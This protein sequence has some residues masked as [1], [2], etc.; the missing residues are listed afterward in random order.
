M[1]ASTTAAPERRPPRGGARILRF[2]G[3]ERLFHWSFALP[4][5]LL[6]VSGVILA[7]PDTQT[8]LARR[9]LIRAIHLYA[10]V[11]LVLLPAAALLTD[12]RGI[13]RDLHEIDYWDR[14]DLRWLRLATIPSFL[15]K[16]PLPAAGR[17]NAGQ[18]LNAVLAAAGITGLVITGSLMW[19]AELFPIWSGEVATDLHDLLT[20]LMLPLVLGHVFLAT[21]YPS[22]RASMMGMVTGRV[23]AIWHRAHH[24]REAVEDA[25]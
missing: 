6:L 22:T 3:G 18:K 23:D 2:S 1:A 13:A 19:K 5:L 12:I 17:F 10:A 8:L 15:R 24:G 11:A 25:G 7:L 21:L 20:L 16:D 14:L 9:E 4:F